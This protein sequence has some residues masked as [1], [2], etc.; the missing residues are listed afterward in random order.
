MMIDKKVNKYL[1]EQSED[2]SLYDLLENDNALRDRVMKGLDRYEKQLG[3]I[4][5]ELGRE[6]DRIER[7]L[8]KEL[9]DVGFVA[10]DLR[11]ELEDYISQEY[12]YI[13]GLG[14]NDDKNNDNDWD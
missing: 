3:N 5:K 12:G 1:K 4:S 6:L 14:W 11:E 2:I 7:M 9:E 13:V 8:V 10:L